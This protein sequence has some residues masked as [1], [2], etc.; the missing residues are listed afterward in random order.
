MREEK[1]SGSSGGYTVNYST[2]DDIVGTALGAFIARGKAL[3][4]ER[5]SKMQLS[6]LMMKLLSGLTVLSRSTVNNE[7]SLQSC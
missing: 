7:R 5:T 1:G 4:S 6:S 2:M 3:R